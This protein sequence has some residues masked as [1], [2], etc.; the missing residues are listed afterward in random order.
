MRTEV[1]HEAFEDF[2]QID[3]QINPGNS[4]GALVNIRG[5]LVGIN[6]AVAG[7]PDRNVG[8]GFAIP[9]NMAKIVKSELIVHGRTRRGSLGLV[10]EDLSPEAAPTSMIG[11]KRGAVITRVVPGSPAAAAG[12]KPGD[13][14]V[15]VGSKPVR[16]AAEY[17]TRVVTLPI[18]VPVVL[19]TFV[20][21]R[22]A[23]RSLLATETVIGP[24]ERVLPQDAG[25]ISGAVVGDIL[26]GNPLYGDIRG[27]QVLKVPGNIPLVRSVSGKATSSSALT[28]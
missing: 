10:V 3:A 19:T 15:G 28:A 20:D 11:A 26:P 16:G 13:I 18:D 17:T 22:K 24:I 2:M 23:Q 12:L 7:G 21:G 6:T 5:E 27:T 9:I 8:I 1:G 4:G 25:S 14:V